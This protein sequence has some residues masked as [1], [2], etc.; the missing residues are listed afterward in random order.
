[1]RKQRRKNCVAVKRSGWE[2]DNVAHHKE[3]A[4]SEEGTWRSST[5]HQ[6]AI[7]DKAVDQWKKRKKKH[8]LHDGHAIGA[9]MNTEEDRA[10][11]RVRPASRWGGGRRF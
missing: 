11:R 5:T 2:K 3:C 1:M 4:K 8:P 7:R 10:M 9:L 6:R